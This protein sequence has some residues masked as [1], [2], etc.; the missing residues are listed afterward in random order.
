MQ[1][2]VST[3]VVSALPA[4]P[5]VRQ[6]SVAGD[7]VASAHVEGVSH[8]GIVAL[9]F[10]AEVLHILQLVSERDRLPVRHEPHLRT[11]RT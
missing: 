4:V 7:L 5:R 11:H 3:L 8:E 10:L 1:C 9:L 2:E 6:R